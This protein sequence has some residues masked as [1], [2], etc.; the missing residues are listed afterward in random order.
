MNSSI[1]ELIIDGNNA[2]RKNMFKG[3]GISAGAA[4]LRI[5]ADYK[6]KFPDSYREI[7]EILFKPDYGA[8][9]SYI[10]AENAVSSS[11]FLDAKKICSQLS[12]DCIKRDLS[13]E[14][15][16]CGSDF[17]SA[18][19]TA[20]SIIKGFERSESGGDV[21]EFF[22]SQT[23]STEQ[24]WSG[25]YET[26]PGLWC[27]A[28]MT[29]FI[30]KDWRYIRS[31]RSGVNHAA[32]ISEK[33]DYTIVFAN[34]SD[35]AHHYNVC[36]RNIEKA[37]SELYCI[38]TAESEEKKDS[39]W[40]RV[41]DK[42][43]P[44][45]K[46]TGRFYRIDV[47]PHTVLTCT[48]LS[49]EK[50]NGTLSVKKCKNAPGRLELPYED[51]FNYSDEF[52]KNGKSAPLYT[53]GQYGSFEIKRF[54]EENVLEQ[55]SSESG[56]GSDPVIAIGDKSWSNYSVRAEVIFENEDARS[57]AGIGLRHNFN[58]SSGYNDGYQLRI[59]PDGKW[60][61]IY[62]GVV[63]EEGM[64]EAISADGWNTLKISA[65]RNIIK[66]CV[67][68][69][70]LCEHAVSE[71][72]IPSGC[73]ALYSSFSRIRFK[74]LYI[75]SISGAA[76]CCNVD[77]AVSGNIKYGE[78]WTKE[79]SFNNINVYRA[80][81]KNAG[82]EYEFSGETI[83]LV[84]SAENLRLKIEIDD[85]IMTAGFI[86]KKCGLDQAFWYKSGLSEGSH[87]IKLTI[88][89]GELSL[90]SIVTDEC[91]YQNKKTVLMLQ[92]KEKDRSPKKLKKSTLFI[93]AGL[94]AAGVGAFVINKLFGKRKK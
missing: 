61:L 16:L 25:F 94:A 26:A 45:R 8:G 89:S 3:V 71:P 64:E 91:V 38:E 2:D 59:F 48:T 20:D 43:I 31:M 72:I 1:K 74:N 51:S 11:L 76:Y 86:I 13:A 67:N 54:E 93:G 85:K 24:P 79:S 82:F 35:N 83:A 41:I 40:F 22:L 77:R 87:K 49:V 63:A 75:N 62:S 50:V 84:G 78:G 36:V 55:T 28:H 42:I 69:Q 44:A 14:E 90:H 70:I 56:S 17:R 5:L 6:I 21:P 46:N 32:F 15:S 19:K 73:A 9:F 57:Y 4:S 80:D 33:G 81:K 27:A 34:D 53:V 60:Q 88:L 7:T 39:N 68:R 18:V 37:D 66:C 12:A 92:K 23:I 10:K 58:A 47:K 30:K 65:V 29:Y 52:L